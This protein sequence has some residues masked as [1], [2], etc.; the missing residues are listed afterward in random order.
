MANAHT[1]RTTKIVVS[2]TPSFSLPAAPGRW[3]GKCLIRDGGEGICVS[4]A[5]HCTGWSHSLSSE[6]C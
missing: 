1:D 2:F 6:E 4:A 3:R 5:A